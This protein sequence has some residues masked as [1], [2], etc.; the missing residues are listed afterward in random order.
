M[1]V[2]LIIN[3]FNKMFHY[4]SEVPQQLDQYIIERLMNKWRKKIQRGFLRL[5]VLRMFHEKDEDDEYVGYHG[6]AIREKIAKITSKNWVPST[7]S[8]YPVLKELLEDNLIMPLDEETGEKKVYK[9]TKLG[10]KIYEQLEQES[11][12]IHPRAENFSK[13]IPKEILKQG[14]K[15]AQQYRLKNELENMKERFEIFVEVLDEL[16]KEKQQDTNK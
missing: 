4:S 11:P 10:I 8:L 6:W 7:G 16:I 12:L 15:H 14:F 5:I 13:R 2:D 9:I 1:E 3:Q